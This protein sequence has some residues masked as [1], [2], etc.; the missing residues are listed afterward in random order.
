MRS[1]WKG[2]LGS[3]HRCVG[4]SRLRVGCGR[5]ATHQVPDGVLERQ[6]TCATREDDV[7]LGVDPR[8]NESACVQM[9]EFREHEKILSWVDF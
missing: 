6:A 2:D 3:A 4:G 5:S 8:V 7:L 9:T 1:R